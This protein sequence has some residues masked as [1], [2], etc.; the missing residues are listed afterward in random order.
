MICCKIT[1]DYTIIC[2]NFEAILK[3]LSQNGIVL[4]DNQKLYF[5]NVDNPKIGETFVKKVLKK[6]NCN[7]FFLEIY[8]AK[9]EPRENDSA[10]YWIENQLVA[11]GYAEVE[12]NQQDLLKQMSEQLTQID[13]ELT[14]ALSQPKKGTAADQ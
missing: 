6:N 8:N 13:E 1:A 14:K 3:Q 11:I 4:W 10:N 7:N 2:Q 5:A 12:K 9:H